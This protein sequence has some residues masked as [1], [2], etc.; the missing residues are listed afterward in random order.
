MATA[1][2]AE[3]HGEGDGDRHAA[4]PRHG[5]LMDLAL[6]VGLIEQ[7]VALRDEADDRGDRKAHDQGHG[8]GEGGLHRRRW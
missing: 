5:L 3:R 2:K 8:E 1:A 6:G 7:A 4:Q